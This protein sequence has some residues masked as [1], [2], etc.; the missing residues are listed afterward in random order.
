MKTYKNYL[1]E[2][3]GVNQDVIDFSNTINDFVEDKIINIINKK[4][5]IKNKYIFSFPIKNI[6]NIIVNNKKIIFFKIIIYTTI[7]TS[8]QMYIELNNDDTFNIKLSLSPENTGKISHSTI[9]HEIKHLYQFS[10]GII[11]E[12]EK[13]RFIGKNKKEKNIYYQLNNIKKY[14]KNLKIESFN[15]LIYFSLGEEIDARVQ[16]CYYNLKEKNTTKK[17]FLENLKNDEEY[18]IMLCVKNMQVLKDIKN[19]IKFVSLW[20]Y[21]YK[22]KEIFELDNEFTGFYKILS[23]I[24]L[25]SQFKYFFIKFFGPIKKPKYIKKNSIFDIF[26]YENVS[27]KE[28][29]EFLNKWEEFFTKQS[30]KFE[31]KLS[32]LY[33]LF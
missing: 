16:A 12:G 28:S 7:E 6:P 14:Y 27:K 4:R 23:K 9:E 3:V 31:M 32:K 8:N 29:E 13:K 22:N 19:P 24:D 21:L 26:F 20:K 33:S 2:K 5:F 25:I 10:R 18:K 17:I 11:G 30:R 15:K 1:L